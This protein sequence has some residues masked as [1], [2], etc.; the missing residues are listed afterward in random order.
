MKTPTRAEATMAD[1]GIRI[2]LIEDDPV[3]IALVEGLLRDE[4]TLDA[5]IEAVGRLDAGLARIRERRPDVLLLD[6][7]LPDSTRL[8]TFYR[9]QANEPNLPVVVQTAVDDLSLAMKAMDAGAQD[10]LM[11]DRINRQTLARSIRY[12]LERTRA[13]SGE[14]NSPMFRLAQQQLL[15][16]AQVMDLDDNVR[17]RL[18]FPQRSQVAALPF[19]RERYGQVETVFGYR[20]QHVLTMGPTKGGIR[21]HPDV[22]LGEVSALAMWMTW[23]C[24]LVRLPFGG[25]KGGVRID[26]ARFSRTELQRMTRRY[27]SEFIGML[28]PD[29]D[30]PAP[31][32]GTDEQVMAWILDTYSQHA[33]YTVPAVVTGKPVELFGSLGRKEATGRGLVDVVKAAAKHLD[34][35]LCGA[36]AVVQ[37]FGNVG[38]YAALLLHAAG[39]R[40]VGVSDASTGL[41]DSKGLDLAS[42]TA[43]VDE[44][45][46]LE[47]YPHADALTN[48]ELLEL[49]CEVL[50]PCAIQNQITAANASRIRCRILAEGANGPTSLEA[51]EILA[52]RDVFVIP[53]I[54]CNAGGVTVSY[55]EWVQG[56]QNVMWTLDEIHR[57]LREILVAGFERMSARARALAVDNRTAALVEGVERV[58]RAN[59]ARGLFP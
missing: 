15:K 13:R 36:R 51:D 35:D 31:D 1:A 21:F 25:A 38:R 54:L 44:H 59:L 10:Y 6:L 27:T 24:A 58:T 41:Y 8:D 30:I 16:A 45:G 48:A 50:A 22:D 43:W 42:L 39:M 37:G 23:K 29:K 28:G 4:P 3:H 7:N 14:W 46:L 34:L 47:G 20:V 11:K 53:D 19:R 56:Y 33:G 17:Q 55:F 52:E 5:E 2:L 9:V 49:P 26:P 12:V 18:L 32:L 40:V 57:R